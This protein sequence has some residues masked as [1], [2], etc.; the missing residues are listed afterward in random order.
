MS[1]KPLSKPQPPLVIRLS[2]IYTGNDYP[3]LT[4]GQQYKL[5]LYSTIGGTWQMFTSKDDTE[6]TVSGLYDLCNN[7]TQICKI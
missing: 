3:N 7:F 2:A 5:N 6:L 1:R 4:Q